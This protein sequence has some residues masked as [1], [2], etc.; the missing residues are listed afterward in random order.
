MT[1]S[2]EEH[3]H[4]FA[5]WCAASA[6]RSSYKCRFSVAS[7]VAL[8]EKIGLKE[9]AKSWDVLPSANSFDEIHRE[10]RKRMVAEAPRI[11]GQ[12]KNRE[13]T[14]GV[15]AKLINCYLKPLFVIGIGKDHES[16]PSEHL[17]K[18]NAIHPPLDR[19][20]LGA[21]IKGEPTGRAIWQSAQK[22]GWSAFNSEEYEEV[23]E[24]VRECTNGRL[25]CIEEHWVGFQSE[26]K[27]LLAG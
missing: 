7:G 24:A 25:W 27:P 18:L 1:Y 5:G 23:I 13:F 20:L 21:L 19:V 8:I 12:G 26:M 4:R 22:I 15:A 2:I 6:A 3:R 10:W 16:M 17:E 9:E 14:H 11:V